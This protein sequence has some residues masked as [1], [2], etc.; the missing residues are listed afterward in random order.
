MAADLSDPARIRWSRR[1]RR[2]SVRSTY[3]PLTFLDVPEDV[4]RRRMADRDFFGKLVLAP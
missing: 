3:V 4:R 1:K 2:D